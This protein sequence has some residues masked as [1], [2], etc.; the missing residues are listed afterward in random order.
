MRL[1]PV[2]QVDPSVGPVWPVKLKCTWKPGFKIPC[3]DK[4]SLVIP[5]KPFSFFCK[6]SE[7]NLTWIT[8]SLCY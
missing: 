3:A 2:W 7:V 4:T 6:T 1:G 8:S 5:A